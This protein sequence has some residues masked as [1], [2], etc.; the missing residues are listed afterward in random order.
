MKMSL[1][2]GDEGFTSRM[3]PHRGTWVPGD[4]KHPSLEY[5]VRDKEAILFKLQIIV[6][7]N[8]TE[9]YEVTR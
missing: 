1:D 4:W 9:V 7:P 6:E 3:C 5:H 2:H 8:N